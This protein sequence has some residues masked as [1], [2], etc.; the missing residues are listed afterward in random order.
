MPVGLAAL[1]IAPLRGAAGAL[2]RTPEY[3]SNEKTGENTSLGS[4]F[5]REWSISAEYGGWSSSPDAR[6]HR[7]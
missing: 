6:R 2:P 5:S 4:G 7:F 3:L 1:G